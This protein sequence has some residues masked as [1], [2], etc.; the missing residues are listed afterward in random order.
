MVRMHALYL[1][2]YDV[3]SMRGLLGA[4]QAEAVAA[5]LFLKAVQRLELYEWAPG[6]AAPAKLFTCG[7][8]G[9]TPELLRERRFFV[10][11]AASEEDG[12]AAPAAAQ[13]KGSSAE[14]FSSS[15]YVACFESHGGNGRLLQRQA[16]LI[17]QACGGGGSRA[18]A[19]EASQCAALCLAMAKILLSY[20]QTAAVIGPSKDL[21]TDLQSVVAGPLACRWC[22]MRLW[23]ARCQGPQTRQ[24]RKR[25]RAEHFVSCPSH[26]RGCPCTSTVGHLNP[27]HA[28][29]GSTNFDTVMHTGLHAHQRL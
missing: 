11:A 20:V 23:P 29:C 9:A 2:E 14:A 7:L 25:W 19:A 18:L 26:R 17:A 5:L 15:S 13:G 3:G 24:I 1:Q 21:F 12:G 27:L 28:R 4:L 10:R 16:F 8:G 6:E 22:R